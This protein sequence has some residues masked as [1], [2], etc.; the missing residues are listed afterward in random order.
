VREIALDD[1]QAE[2]PDTAVYTAESAQYTLTD[3]GDGYW[4]IRHQPT[5]GELEEAEGADILRNVELLRF[6]DGCF[7]IGT[8]EPCG[9]YGSASIT[10]ED[11]PTEDVPVTGSVVFNRAAVNNPTDI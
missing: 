9:D 7:Q 1:D 11:V 6:A 8:M 10:Y 4:R 3:L 5:T 2:T